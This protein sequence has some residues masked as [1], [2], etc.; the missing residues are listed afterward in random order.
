MKYFFSILLLTVMINAKD[1]IH[2]IASKSCNFNTIDYK[3]IKD[4]F[5]KKTKY[6][7]NTQIKV[8]DNKEYYNNFILQYL[9]KSPS[10]M[11]I[12]WTRMI[13]TGSKKPP[14]K[15]SAYKLTNLQESCCTISYTTQNDIRGWKVLDVVP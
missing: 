1:D 2:I 8:F 11:R 14:K 10:K 12:Y 6:Y 4:L 9:K 7:N 15:I 3:S 13:F 5:M